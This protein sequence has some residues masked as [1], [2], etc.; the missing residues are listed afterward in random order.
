MTAELTIQQTS[1]STAD[2]Q[3][4]NIQ[5]QTKEIGGSYADTFPKDI[6][7]STTHGNSSGSGTRLFVSSFAFEWVHALTGDELTDGVQMKILTEGVTQSGNGIAKL[8]NKQV[9][10]EIL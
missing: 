7:V 4:V 8:Q 2:N 6:L 3:H 10:I 9:V 5:L 1:V